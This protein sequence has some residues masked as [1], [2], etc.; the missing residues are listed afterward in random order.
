MFLVI[1]GVNITSLWIPDTILSGSVFSTVLDCVYN[2]TEEDKTSLEVKW[3]FRHDPS[4]V[5]QWVPPN[6][7]QVLSPL[8]K[9]HLVSQFE[10]SRDPYTMYRALNL[11]N[12]DTSLSGSYSCR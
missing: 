12:I 10:V 9:E 8:F 1:N 3:Y 4:P 6:R 7:P 5:Y 11:V 2:Y